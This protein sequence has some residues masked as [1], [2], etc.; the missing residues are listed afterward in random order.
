MPNRRVEIPKGDGKVRTLQLL[1]IRGGVVQGA[2]KLI[3][4]AVFG[5]DFCPTSHGFRPKRSPH[6]VLAEVRRSVMRHL[7]NV[8]EVDLSR[9]FDTIQQSVL[10]DQI[11][12]RIQGPQVM[13]LV[14]QIIKAG[15]MV[16]I[17]ERCPSSPLAANI[18]LS[19][20]DWYFEA[21]R[22]RTV[23]GEYGAVNYHRFAD[24]LFITASRHPTKRGW[25]E[26]A[27]QQ[28]GEA[29]GLTGFDLH[30]VPKQ[31]GDGHFILMTPK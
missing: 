23:E 4:E 13:H 22:R 21:I 6:R 29:L 8:I 25:A 17:P 18:Y 14:K 28:C 9:D 2:L 10:L 12:K 27:L 20:V 16:G 26:R 30:R 1:C 24:D 3:P 15:G 19:E 31:S 11:A 5:A 7:S